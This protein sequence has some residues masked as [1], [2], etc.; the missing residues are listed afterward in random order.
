MFQF[1]QLVNPNFPSDDSRD[2]TKD[3]KDG[4]S[5]GPFHRRIIRNGPSK[6]FRHEGANYKYGKI[7][8]TK[9][10]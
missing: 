6:D 10:F 9:Q 8:E 5:R 2:C 4:H 3:A 7:E 1:S